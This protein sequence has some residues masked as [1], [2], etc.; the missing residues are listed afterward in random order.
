MGR[1]PPRW[2]EAMIPLLLELLLGLRLL[3]G[4]VL[5]I[6]GGNWLAVTGSGGSECPDLAE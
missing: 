5:A 4:E 3:L 6:P 2:I 1:N